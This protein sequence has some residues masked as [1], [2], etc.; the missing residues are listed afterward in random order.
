MK[1][2]RAGFTLL[3]LMIA[4]AIAVIILTMAIPSITGMNQEKRLRESFEKL[5][6]FTY[7]AQSKAVS[8][9]RSWVLVWD[10]TRILLQ[11]NE[12]TPEE[13]QDGGASVQQELVFG[14]GESYT[15][16]RPYALMPKESTPGDWT[17]WRSGTC[18]AVIIHYQGPDGWWS[19]KYH[20][21]T[22][23]GEITEQELY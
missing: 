8:E 1:Q 10:K 5:D 3:E 13:M 14:Q 23:H 21:L 16:E 19:A 7:K 22:G 2:P 20:P 9:Q 12:P 4:I 11:P 6:A 17:F 15:I 18:E